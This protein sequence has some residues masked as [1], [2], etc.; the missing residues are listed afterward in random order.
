[1]AKRSYRS[2]PRKSYKPRRSGGAK[3]AS[4]RTERVVIQIVQP[5]PTAPYG[6]TPAPA[7]KGRRF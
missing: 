4:G 5:G 1:M 6:M 3:R 7:P 2:A